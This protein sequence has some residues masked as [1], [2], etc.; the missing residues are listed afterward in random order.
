MAA[1]CLG[2]GHA[3]IAHTRVH[4]AERSQFGRQLCKFP[5]VQEQ[6]AGMIADLYAAEAVERLVC[7]LFD[8]KTGDIALDSTVAKIIASEA[9]WNIIDRGVQLLG[10]AGFM[11]ETGMPRRLRD[12]RVTRIFEGANDVLRLHLAMSVI[13]WQSS[14]IETLPK[15]ASTVRPELAAAAQEF[16]ALAPELFTALL[17]A[18]RR[19]GFRLYEHQGLQSDMA[20]GMVCVYAMMASILRANGSLGRIDESL[21]AKE[22]AIVGFA[23]KRL[24]R[25]ARIAIDKVRADRAASDAAFV[26]TILAD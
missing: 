6:T 22:A 19:L 11:E 23:C 12:L 8:T 16:D 14:D 2:A 25:T 7:E 26:G 1:G 3:A 17:A 20:D 4:T 5:L 15:L 21:R 10:G 18:R 24:A 13:G 9:S